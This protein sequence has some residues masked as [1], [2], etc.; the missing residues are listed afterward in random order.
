MEAAASHGSQCKK[1]S[2]LMEIK[3]KTN[4]KILIGIMF[5]YFER[6]V[7]GDLLTDAIPLLFDAGAFACCVST[8]GQC[9]SL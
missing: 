2:C 1:T 6:A 7:K 3:F 4:Q 8:L 9:A 5:D